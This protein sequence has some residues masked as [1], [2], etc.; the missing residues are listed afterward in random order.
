[1][2]LVLT[3]QEHRSLPGNASHRATMSFLQTNTLLPVVIT[4]SLHISLAWVSAKVA[5]RAAE[6]ALLL[7]GVRGVR[8]TRHIKHLKGDFGTC[9]ASREMDWRF[10]P[11]TLLKGSRW[12]RTWMERHTTSQL[13]YIPHVYGTPE[14]CFGCHKSGSWARQV[15][16]LNSLIF[17]F[18]QPCG[19]EIEWSP[20]Y[21]NIIFGF[22]PILQIPIEGIAGKIV[23]HAFFC[24]LRSR[25]V[26]L[27]LS[28]AYNND[29]FFGKNINCIF[30]HFVP[31]RGSLIGR[32]KLY[33]CT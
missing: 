23:A 14:E 7:V 8:G 15:S 3:I 21:S 19:I 31:L 27:L 32:T 6:N 29:F 25:G 33:R 30:S 9:C 24:W 26:H 2:T 13:N 22:K 28:F 10:Y 12:A 1:M 4:N 16:G 17:R 18:F 5:P 11:R 20:V